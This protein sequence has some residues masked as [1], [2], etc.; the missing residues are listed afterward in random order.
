M[1]TKYTTFEFVLLAVGLSISILG[2][3]MINQAY[4][5]DAYKV[6]WPMLISIFSWMNILVMLIV[7][8]L[9]IDSTKKK[10]K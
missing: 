1:R 3:H 4:I 2:F 6:S 9:I 8:G 10:W 5:A 7:T